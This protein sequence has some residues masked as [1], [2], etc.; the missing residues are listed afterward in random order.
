LIF[1]KKYYIIYI[2]SERK[3]NKK[4]FHLWANPVKLTLVVFNIIGIPSRKTAEI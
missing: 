2:Q 3:I 4:I 1:I